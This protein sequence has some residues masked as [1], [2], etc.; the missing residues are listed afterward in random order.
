MY[1]KMKE[2][3]KSLV[4]SSKI[5]KDFAKLNENSSIEELSAF[6]QKNNAL[7]G[8]L[9]KSDEEKAYIEYQRLAGVRKNIYK[10][11]ANANECDYN[12]IGALM[13]FDVIEDFSD[14]YA[15]IEK[16]NKQ[17]AEILPQ[18]QAW[19]DFTGNHNGR[20]LS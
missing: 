15:K 20:T 5:A 2:I 6:C 10:F 16:L 3:A 8:S 1:K 4:P 12:D 14:E 7:F 9:V 17:I 18:A 19:L 13:T 11:I